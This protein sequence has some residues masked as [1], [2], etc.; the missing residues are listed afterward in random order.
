MDRKGGGYVKVAIKDKPR[1]FRHSLAS[2]LA[3]RPFDGCQADVFDLSFYE[4]I[5][6]EGG[7]LFLG[8]DKS[9]GFYVS[10]IGEVGSVFKAPGSFISASRILA[11][12]VQNGGKFLN[13]Y[14]TYR[15]ET[16]YVLSKFNPV[17]RMRFD[18][19]LAPAGWE[20]TSLASKPD[21]AFFVHSP[22]GECL[23]GGG[24][25]FDDYDEAFNFMISRSKEIIYRNKN[26]V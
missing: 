7:H 5:I 17:A 9:C 26:F 4:K 1:I 16:V 11:M 25:Y 23:I 2:A 10:G 15:M 8:L 6:Q 22:F 19:S 14:A 18:E 24:E 3:S 13:A 21:V 20:N 12:A